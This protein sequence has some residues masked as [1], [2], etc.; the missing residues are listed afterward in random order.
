MISVGL[1]PEHSTSS[2]AALQEVRLQEK[3]TQH[4][5]AFAHLRGIFLGSKINKEGGGKQRKGF[6]SDH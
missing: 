5:E 6:L 3:S 1:T 2:L 4:T